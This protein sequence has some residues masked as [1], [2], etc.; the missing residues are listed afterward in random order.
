MNITL[1]LKGQLC[2]FKVDTGANITVIPGD[3]YRS[4]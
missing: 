3:S 1:Y 4:Y 2:Q